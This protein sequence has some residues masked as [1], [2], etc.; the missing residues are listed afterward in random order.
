MRSLVLKLKPK[1]L[2]IVLKLQ[3]ILRKDHFQKF[4][5]TIKLE[6]SGRNHPPLKKRYLI[7]LCKITTN[8][9]S[10][11]NL[12]TLKIKNKIIIQLYFWDS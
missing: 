3:T 12:Y 8:R 11:K 7:S 1:I 5:K 9:E 4:K 6:I 2:S 10:P